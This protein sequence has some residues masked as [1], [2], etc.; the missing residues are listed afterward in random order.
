MNGRTTKEIVNAF[1]GGMNSDVDI[2]SIQPNQYLYAKNLRTTND[3]SNSMGAK[4]TIEFPE[5]VLSSQFGGDTVI[6][7]NSSNGFSIVFGKSTNKTNVYIV[8]EDTT[9]SVIKAA[10]ITGY[11]PTHISS[12]IRYEGDD[13]I[14]LYFADGVNQIMS[15]KLSMTGPT[16]DIASIGEV[17]IVPVSNLSP[18]TIDSIGS[19]NLLAGRIQYVYQCYNELG[20]NTA[21]SIPSQMVNLSFKNGNGGSLTDTYGEN[22]GSSVTLK[23][24]TH[25]LTSF[26]GIK[27]YSIYYFNYDSTP[28]ITLIYDSETSSITG[29]YLYVSDY[30]MSSLSELTIDEF[31]SI[32][33]NI[34]SAREIEDRDNILFAANTKDMSFDIEY[35]T[36]AFQFNLG[37]N[38]PYPGGMPVPPSAML[39][40]A[41]LKEENRLLL[42]S[43]NIDM[44]EELVPEDHDCINK[45]IYEIEKY[46]D[47]EYKYDINGNLGGSGKNV[48]YVFTNAL[49]IGAREGSR[50]SNYGVERSDRYIDDRIV[51]I[52]ANDSNIESIYLQSSDNTNSEVP[53][54]MFGIEEHTGKLDYS[55]PLIAGTLASYKRDEIYRFSAVIH[56]KSG[57]KT[58]AKWIAD[59]RFPVA[60]EQLD[61]EYNS[62]SS[63]TFEM[64]EDI[65]ATNYM[66]GS[67]LNQYLLD[68]E[69]IIKPLGIKFTFR[70]IP[71]DAS[72]IE[73]FRAKR[74]H[75]NRTILSQGVLQKTGTFNNQKEATKDY[76]ATSKYYDVANNG[77]L[78]PHPI[79]SMG[80][81]YAIAPIIMGNNSFN[82]GLLNSVKTGGGSTINFEQYINTVNMHPE[83]Y[84]SLYSQAPYFSS[85]EN[86]MFI[87]PDISYYNEDGYNAI[88][89]SIMSSYLSFVT[90]TYPKC[91]S[92]VK[93]LSTDG[94]VAYVGR[95]DHSRLRYK[96]S[97][98]GLGAYPTAMYSGADLTE[99]LISL[100]SDNGIVSEYNLMYTAG[101]AGTFT[102]VIEG[103]GAS[104]IGD[105]DPLHPLVYLTKKYDIAPPSDT[106][107]NN[108]TTYGMMFVS[109][110]GLVTCSV[111]QTG[112]SYSRYLIYKSGIPGSRINYSDSSLQSNP[113]QSDIQKNYLDAGFGNI[114]FKYYNAYKKKASLNGSFS[115]GYT[116]LSLVYQDAKRIGACTLRTLDAPYKIESVKINDFAY[117]KDESFAT[118]HHK[119]SSTTSIG[120]M[121]YMNFSKS[122]SNFF[123]WPSSNNFSINNGND[124]A[125]ARAKISGIHG[126]GLLIN[127]DE[128][129]IPSIEKVFYRKQKYDNG[130]ADENYSKL[131]ARIA[132]GLGTF[133]VDIKKSNYGMYGGM[134]YQDRQ[135]TEYIST[136]SF[137]TN[138]DP[139]YVFSGDTYINMFDYTVTHALDQVDPSEGVFTEIGDHDNWWNDTVLSQTMR[140][141]AI[142]PLES[143]INTMVDAGGTYGEKKNILI[144]ALPG[145]YSIGASAGI[146]YIKSQSKNEHSYNSAYSAQQTAFPAFSEIMNENKSDEY[147]YRIS[148]SEKKV[149]GE[150]YDGWS[151][152]MPSNYIDVDSIAGDI[153]KL[154]NFNNR[155]YF[156]QEYGIGIVSVNE[157]SLITD[158]NGSEL[159]LGT[160]G[161]LSRYDYLSKSYGMSTLTPN[162]IFAAQSGIYMYDKTNNVIVQVADSVSVHSKNKQIQ[163]YI[164]ASKDDISDSF[165]IG[166]NK[167]Y[168]EI[169]FSAKKIIDKYGSGI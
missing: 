41:D 134:S 103:V 144:Q 52:G 138:S 14:L 109:G 129:K 168:N 151:I 87:S 120:G 100:D 161:I 89:N 57:R 98:I 124:R 15:I 56:N 43:M 163:S 81:A 49:L 153:S 93:S 62:W 155:L 59:I 45:D 101:L 102:N 147:K 3:E 19:G 99:E 141:G 95:E 133:I 146:D 69:L 83:K 64:P 72:R 165:V 4:S 36:R 148:A 51:R 106:T 68:Q 149:L 110:I 160:G 47:I 84:A 39:Y 86:F 143:Q 17:Y 132:A 116:Y 164:N 154:K 73:I 66:F 46:A 118:P 108:A 9:L 113:Y 54:H 63:A 27:I 127:V 58:K 21:V 78:R 6:H 1:S 169:L 130:T 24:P 94:S 37:S 77:T 18:I 40:T 48:D 142:L 157:R 88:K 126:A 117:A 85:N 38:S 112:G 158:G 123:Q 92:A 80:Y 115:T 13:R 5:T 20:S 35:D 70:N 166:E 145:A 44:V 67:T 50:K 10:T 25:S 2:S 156:I 111:D 162:A 8:R 7:T 140:V 33:K 122:L 131:E 28:L 74:D 75:F 107:P 76:Y 65:D 22:V 105:F 125:I 71:T 128:G 23:I 167:K 11:L 29:D 55:N 61:S 114:T 82:A 96:R 137:A 136:G 60:T 97:M 32:A 135:F 90:M 31:V 12:V 53:V 42:S 16:V 152:F 159:S 30:G 150:M 121:Q 91:T 139:V 26:K 119:F 104:L 34:F 79:I